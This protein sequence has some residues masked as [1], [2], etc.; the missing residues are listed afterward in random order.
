MCPVCRALP[1]P[2]PHAFPCGSPSKHC[3]ILFMQWVSSSVVLL[4]RM[5]EL[6]CILQSAMGITV[7]EVR[8]VDIPI[9]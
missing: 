5:T 4:E 2:W 3:P 9:T 1:I 6:L 8:P 7:V